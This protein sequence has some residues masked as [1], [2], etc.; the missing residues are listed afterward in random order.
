MR[1]TLN[2]SL[3]ESQRWFLD[4]ALAPAVPFSPDLQA[5]ASHRSNRPKSF[6]HDILGLRSKPRVSLAVH[7]SD[8]TTPIAANILVF[9]CILRVATLFAKLIALVRVP[10]CHFW[11]PAVHLLVILVFL[12][13]KQ[14]LTR[15]FD[16]FKLHQL[17]SQIKANRFL[18]AG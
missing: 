5:R 18:A 4:T 2:P 6:F 1:Q 13:S 3:I 12:L 7:T 9:F 10:D 16:C 17:L 8:A 15:C 14:D 11:Q